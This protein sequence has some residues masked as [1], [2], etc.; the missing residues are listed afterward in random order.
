[1]SQSFYLCCLFLHSFYVNF[2]RY[3]HH[4]YTPAAIHH[5]SRKG[6]VLCRRSIFANHDGRSFGSLST[7]IFILQII[8][9]Y[10]HMPERARS[11]NYNICIAVIINSVFFN[12]FLSISRYICSYL[13]YFLQAR[14]KV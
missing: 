4:R 7:V 14:I 12:V 1:M 6:I 9:M 11:D 10:I 3:F 5:V 13:S 2:Y 8:C